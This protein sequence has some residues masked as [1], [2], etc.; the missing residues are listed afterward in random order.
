[1]ISPCWALPLLFMWDC[2]DSNSFS[3]AAPPK[4]V[5]LLQTSPSDQGNSGKQ[6]RN[7]SGES[8]GLFDMDPPAVMGG[9]MVSVARYREPE[10]EDAPPVSPSYKSALD[11][12]ATLD[13][14]GP[15]LGCGAA[16][17][18][19]G[20]T[21]GASRERRAVTGEAAGHSDELSGKYPA[22]LSPV[23]ELPSTSRGVDANLT[24]CPVGGRRW[25]DQ[26]PAADERGDQHWPEDPVRSV[27]QRHFPISGHLRSSSATR[28]EAAR[29]APRSLNQRCINV[30]QFRPHPVDGSGLFKDHVGCLVQ[31]HADP[32]FTSAAVRL[33]FRRHVLVFAKQPFDFS[34]DR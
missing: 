26:H 25:S 3:R 12:V 13:I 9:S 32:D 15:V 5:C 27:R 10:P 23:H 4:P 2:H 20:T 14:P 33:R 24:L 17:D 19:A 21:A 16:P 6:S 18:P 11:D 29:H 28:P 22:G 34:T 8:S 1:M 30:L 31:A 7:E